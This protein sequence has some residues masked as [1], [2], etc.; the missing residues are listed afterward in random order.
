VDPDEFYNF[1]IHDFFQFKSFG[2]Q[3]PVWRYNFLKFQ[4]L[5]YLKFVK[6]KDDQYIVVDLHNSNN[7]CIYDFLVEII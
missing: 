6:W 4:I 5:S 7:F 2:V 3:N 1:G